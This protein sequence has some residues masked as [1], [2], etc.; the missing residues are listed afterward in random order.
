MKN[1]YTEIEGSPF[2]YDDWKTGTITDV[3][4][5]K[6]NAAL[7]KYDTYMDDLFIFR[8]GSALVLQSETYPEFTMNFFDEDG[9]T[10]LNRKFKHASQLN[11]NGGKGYYEVFYDGEYKLLQKVESEYI[12]K[13]VSDYGTSKEIKKF[14]TFE[15]LILAEPDGTMHEVK[16]S[17][18][19]IFEVFGSEK[20]K[21]ES[22]AKQNKYNVKDEYELAMLLQ[23][24]EE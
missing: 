13:V 17:K 12:Q 19:K 15:R 2:L 4:G 20:K 16:G 10:Q 22:I 24:M 6:Y 3:D 18:K 5:K 1:K 8:D 11:L 7:L 14:N 21:A 9:I 23:R